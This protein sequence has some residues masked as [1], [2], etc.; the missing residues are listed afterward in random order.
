[1]PPSLLPAPP[2]AQDPTMPGAPAGAAAGVLSAAFTAAVH[3]RPACCPALGRARPGA[4]ARAVSRHLPIRVTVSPSAPPSA[5]PVPAGPGRNCDRRIPPS[6]PQPTPA[7]ERQHRHADPE[8]RAV[9]DDREF[10]PFTVLAAVAER[11]CKRPLQEAPMDM[12]P[13]PSELSIN[14][15]GDSMPSKTGNC[16]VIGSRRSLRALAH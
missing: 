1:M 15:R 8:D 2:Q 5:L 4:A 16:D 9:A 11:H 13:S 6:T 10:V 3:A 14:P 12:S 7:V